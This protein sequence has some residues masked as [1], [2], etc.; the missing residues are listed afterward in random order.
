MQKIFLFVLTMFLMSCTHIDDYE[1]VSFEPS[2]NDLIMSG[3]IDS[4][5]KV[6]LQTAL[7]ENPQVTNILMQYVEGSVDDEANLDAA[8]FV[9]EMKLNTTIKSDGL[10]A[11]GGTDFFLAGVNRIV[12]KG[13]KIGVHSWAG[14]DIDDPLKLPRTHPEHKK[15]LEYYK[16]M[17]VPCE[18]YW[19]TLESAPAEDV[20]WMTLS[21][22]KLYKVSTN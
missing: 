20:H 9:R 2:G 3:V 8:R 18:F 10:I 11:S 15:Y 19:Y 1:P 6:R 22:I 17:G 12:E 5:V 4:D 16:D 7:N 13:A 21:E 14:D